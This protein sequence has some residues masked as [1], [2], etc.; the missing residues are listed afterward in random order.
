VSGFLFTVAVL[1]VVLGVL[2]FVHEFGHYWAAKR[3]GVWVHRFSIGMGKPVKALTFQRGETEWAISWLPLGG[4]VK[5]ASAEEEPA[6]S[7]LEGGHSADVPA[8]RVFEAKPIWQRMV[9]ILAGV[10]LNALFAWVVFTGLAWKNGRQFD[11]TTTI[12]RVNTEVLPPE[13]AE[14]ATIPVGTRITAI[15][16]EPVHSWDDIRERVATGNRNEIGISFEG[17]API[18]IK[19]HRDA[20]SERGMTAI[21]LEPQHPAVLGMLTPS[22]PAM[23]AGLQ[24]G[25]SIVAINGQPITQWVDAVGLIRKS[26]GVEARFDVMR[27]GAPLTVVVTPKL[28][29]EVAAD[30]ASPMIGRIGAMPR[31]PLQTESL[32]LIGAVRVGTDLTISSAG[33]IFRTFRGLATRKVAT[34]EIGGPIMIG[35]MAA[36]QA[37]QGIEP[38]LAFMALISMNLAVVNLLPIPVLDGGAFLILLAE[39]IMRRPLPTKV[40]EVISLIGLGMIL[41]IMFVAFKNDIMR[42]LGQ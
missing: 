26:G 37:R 29:R 28:E 3:F 4:Y 13:A 31:Q 38:L 16:G 8:D 27:D 30:T 7:V 11:P 5:M 15:D 39:G 18:V 40:R 19:L 22:S 32:G 1:F 35:Q 24:A 33:A 23:Q 20:L 14:L 36:Q 10:T 25:D 17:H 34:T 9:I 21:A 2:I 42:W 12:G 6:S 41:V